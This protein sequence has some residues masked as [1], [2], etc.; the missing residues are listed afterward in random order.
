MGSRGVADR[1][2]RPIRGNPFSRGMRKNRTESDDTDR[3][4]NRSGLHGRDLVLAQG[5]AHDIK[6][7]RQRRVAKALFSATWPVRSNGGYQRLFR[8]H[9][10]R[11]GFGQRRSDGANTLARA[12]HGS[13]P[14][15]EDQS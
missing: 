10:L 9:K 6:T 2:D 15:P 4:V 5:L 8:I 12:L 1:A 3:F 13:P 11:L 7:A 14:P